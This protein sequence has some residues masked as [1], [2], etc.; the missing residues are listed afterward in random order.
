M[1]SFLF[2]KIY[3]S[4][5]HI[6]TLKCFAYVLLFDFVYFQISVNELVKAKVRNPPAPPKIHNTDK[7][8]K[9]SCWQ[10]FNLVLYSFNNEL[11]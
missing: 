3:K 5:K 10:S 11:F 1:F 6:F 8:W 9:I 4:T 7:N 2:I